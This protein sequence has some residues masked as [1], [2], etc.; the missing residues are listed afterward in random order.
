MNQYFTTW[1]TA[2]YALKSQPAISAMA[3]T[4]S[5]P[6]LP[7]LT[8]SSLLTAVVTTYGLNPAADSALINLLPTGKKAP[9][10]DTSVTYY[11]TQLAGLLADMLADVMSEAGKLGFILFAM[12]GALMRYPGE[13]IAGLEG[14]LSV[15]TQGVAS[16]STYE[17]SS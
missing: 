10:L 2:I 7:R 12:G 5:R 16:T 1:T 13:S 17:I 6:G 8:P 9:L 4:L 3:L 14:R 11:S 15:G